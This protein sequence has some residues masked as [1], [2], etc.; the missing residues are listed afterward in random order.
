M[1]QATCIEEINS[2][3]SWLQTLKDGI[4]GPLGAG[5]GDIV[6]TSGSGGGILS[7]NAKNISISGRITNSS[8]E[9]L[10]GLFWLVGWLDKRNCFVG[11]RRYVK[12][13]YCAG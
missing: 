4:L 13:R 5:R 7:P 9:K 6:K 8:K 12:V 2:D 3:Q 10:N 11:R 1:G